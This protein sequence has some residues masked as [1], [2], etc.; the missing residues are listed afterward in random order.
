[1]ED[2]EIFI[3]KY[4]K[5]KNK[6]LDFFR[7]VPPE[8]YILKLIAGKYKS[9]QTKGTPISETD[10]EILSC[11]IT[12]NKEYRAEK[13]NSKLRLRDVIVDRMIAYFELQ[14]EVKSRYISFKD[15][16]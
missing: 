9:C 1:M 10:K 6:L 5:E 16:F 7:G 2:L 14:N 8:I 13:I 4:E 12:M 11:M 15:Y 3:R